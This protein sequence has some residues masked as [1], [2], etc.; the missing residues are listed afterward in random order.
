MLM[1]L[2]SKPYLKKSFLRLIWQR[3]PHTT[4]RGFCRGKTPLFR[5]SSF[6]GFGSDLRSFGSYASGLVTQFLRLENQISSNKTGAATRGAPG[7]A[8]LEFI[9]PKGFGSC[10]QWWC[11]IFFSGMGSSLQEQNGK[12][13]SGSLIL[14][15][16]ACNCHSRQGH[17]PKYKTPVFCPTCCFTVLQHFELTIIQMSLF[18]VYT[19]VQQ[20]QLF[21]EV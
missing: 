12:T 14:G 16:F 19:T 20:L 10:L 1:Q 21:L 9:I 15:L 18:W 17:L 7:L 2:M 8:I 5:S 6:F 11:G 3:K 13:K 4:N